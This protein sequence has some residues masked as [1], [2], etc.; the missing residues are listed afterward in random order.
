MKFTGKLYL[1][2]K[3]IDACVLGEIQIFWHKP[4]SNIFDGSGHMET[5]NSLPVGN[6]DIGLDILKGQFILVFDTPRYGAPDRL[7]INITDVEEPERKR[8][9]FDLNHVIK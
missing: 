2:D 3:L 8:A 4:L 7:F 5:S 6:V 9:S 1:E